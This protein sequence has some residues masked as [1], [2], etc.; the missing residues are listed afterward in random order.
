ME[1]ILV[2]WCCINRPSVP[3]GIY[4]PYCVTKE[5]HVRD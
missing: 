3:Y 5:S 1:T 4:Q 2:P